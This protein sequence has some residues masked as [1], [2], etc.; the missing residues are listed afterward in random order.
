MPVTFWLHPE[1]TRGPFAA[2]L[3]ALLCAIAASCVFFSTANAQTTIGLYSDASGNTCSFSGNDPGLFTAHVVVRPSNGVTGVQFSA[4]IPTCLGATFVSEVVPTGMLALGS[5]QTGISIALSNCYVGPTSVLQITYLRSGSTELCCEYAIVPD[6]AVVSLSATDCNYQEIGLASQTSHF[7]ADASCACEGNSPPTPPTSPSPYEGESAVSVLTSMAW[8]GFDVDGNL[9]EYDLYLGTTPTPPLVAAGLTEPSYTPAS[10]LTGVTSYYWRVVARDDKGLETSSVIWNFTTRPGN[11]P[12]YVPLVV[13][14]P[15]GASGI[16]LE[17]VLRWSGADLDGDALV[18]DVYFGP[19]TPPPLVARG[20]AESQYSVSSMEYA[21]AYYWR[22]VARDV[23]G[24]ETSGPTWSFATR[25]LNY[26]PNVPVAV[27]PVNGSTGVPLNT[28]LSWTV[29][30]L[31]GDALVSDVYFGSVSPPPLVAS[32]QTG[33]TYA[34]TDLEYSTAYYWRVVVRDE[35]GAETS[36]NAWTFTARPENFPPN[37]PSTPLPGNAAINQSATPTL[38]WQC[39]DLDGHALTYDVY[40]GTTSPP[41]LVASNLAT[42]SYVPGLLTFDTLYRWKVVARDELGAETEGPVWSFSTL[43]NLPPNV[44]SNPVPPNN[45]TNNSLAQTLAWLCSDPNGHT[46]TFDVYFG[47]TTPPPLVASNIT[48][49]SYAPGALSFAT[50]YRWQVVARDEFGLTRTGPTWAFTTKANSPPSVSS[51]NPPN[52]GVTGQTPLLTWSSFD[53]DP[54]RLTF[55]V[56]FGTQT[57]LPLV[58]SG[59]T[60][61]RYEPGMLPYGVYL[62]RVVASDG[63][64]TTTGPTWDFRVARMGDANLDG[65]VTVADAS[66]A[67]G[68]FTYWGPCIMGGGVADVDCNQSVTPRDARCIHK[69]VLDGS[70]TFCDGLA[71]VATE[72]AANSPHVWLVSTT[73]WN[74]TLIAHLGVT[75]VPSLEAF[76]FQVHSNAS[77]M[78]AVRL[79]ATANF[80]ALRANPYPIMGIVGGYSLSG[81]PA[82]D[83]VEFIDLRFYSDY[84]PDRFVIIDGF[85]DDLAGAPPISFF[86]G[87]GGVPVLFSRFDAAVVDAGVEV[88]WDLRADEAMDS[89]TLYRREADAAL[90]EIAHGASMVRSYLDVTVEHGKT[91][92]YELV[93]RTIS[94]DEFRSPIATITMGGLTLVLGQNHPNPFN[95]RTSIPYQLP[96]SLQPQRVHLWIL[97]ISGRIIA[98]LVDEDQSAGE[99]RVDWHGK[100]DRGEAVS[101]GV[102]FTVLDVEGQ[103]RTRKLVLLK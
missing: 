95:P 43:I 91:Y 46:V 33:T 27:A 92:H 6:P 99:Y 82:N 57:P 87:G 12:P 65:S 41:P 38:S 20:I 59:L 69:H 70:C 4:P 60:E 11:S 25:P 64:S 75:G 74:D 23:G 58:A 24:L 83:P 36:G 49:R 100:D 8:Y 19:S 67:L 72:E 21:T 7:N 50:T 86:L 53:P 31:D 51:P 101:S 54:Q 78:R 97:D 48:T 40:F 62:W 9:A 98:T 93:I 77:S 81:V 61:R 10:P 26:P 3:V 52:H 14:P 66:C 5:S 84:W 1:R 34:V 32:G 88:S 55:D 56:Y 17:T 2:P 96:A 47:T 13:S 29:S 30:D 73:E 15:N 28:V 71:S 68:A 63:V 42:N 94:G 79:G 90:R 16:L 44:P 37:V 80:V 35:H 22:I 76:G 89:Y 103:R 85:V 39:S 45:S 102:Y 18:Y